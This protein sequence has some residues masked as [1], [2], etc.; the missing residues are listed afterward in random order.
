MQ[1]DITEILRYLLPMGL[2]VYIG[3]CAYA[4]V[5]ITQLIKNFFNELAEKFGLEWQCNGFWAVAIS[6]IVSYG[7]VYYT[8]KTIP[9]DTIILFKHYLIMTIAVA[10]IANGWFKLQKYFKI[11]ADTNLKQ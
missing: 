5:S 11:R 1:I 10:G 3:G 4:T 2:I 9:I 8:L 7:V 6:I